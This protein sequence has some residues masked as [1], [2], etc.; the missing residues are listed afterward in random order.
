MNENELKN[1]VDVKKV[2]IKIYK[3]NPKEA[4]AYALRLGA[5][6][7]TLT[8]WEFEAKRLIELEKSL[9]LEQQAMPTP[10][11]QTCRAVQTSKV[12]MI[13]CPG[14]GAIYSEKLPFCPQ[15]GANKP[16]EEQEEPTPTEPI[17]PRPIVETHSEQTPKKPQGIEL[18]DTG[19]P[20][21]EIGDDLDA[22]N[23]RLEKLMSKKQNP[24]EII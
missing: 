12:K 10:T 21:S 9:N 1:W 6:M 11:I 18:I 2:F 3:E 22:V 15:C 19:I 20:L 4:R 17:E 14:C 13:N 5:R 7:R 23:E 8:A 16:S 24:D